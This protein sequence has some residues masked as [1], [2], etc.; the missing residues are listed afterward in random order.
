MHLDLNIWDREYVVDDIYNTYLA[1][2]TY[3]HV[4]KL[5]TH[6]NSFIAQLPLIYYHPSYRLEN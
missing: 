5:L 1:P 4:S 2:T 3:G 6:V